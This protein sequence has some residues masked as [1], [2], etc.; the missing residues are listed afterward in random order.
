MHYRGAVDPKEFLFSIFL[1]EFNVVFFKL[2]LE[3]RVI[4]ILE[5]EI[6]VVSILGLEKVRV[7]GNAHR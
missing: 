2:R 4:S 3:K 1:Q 5:W 7:A 6:R